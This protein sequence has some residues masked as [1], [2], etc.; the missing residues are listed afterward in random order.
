MLFQFS[1]P[2]FHPIKIGKNNI[3]SFASV[4]AGR[5]KRCRKAS[6]RPELE[7]FGAQPIPPPDSVPPSYPLT[8]AISG[9][10]CHFRRPT[11][12]RNWN[13]NENPKK[14]N[15][16][17]FSVFYS[18]CFFFSLSLTLLGVIPRLSN[19]RSP[20]LHSLKTEGTVGGGQGQR[21]S[22]GKIAGWRDSSARRPGPM[23]R[24]GL[25]LLGSQM[26]PRAAGM[27]LGALFC[28][29]CFCIHLMIEFFPLR[30][31]L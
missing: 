31:T 16:E 11:R 27:Q 2:N 10:D 8:M 18:L 24:R 4:L 21:F 25:S 14:V 5:S 15:H 1:F 30:N 28:G 6:L 19:F 22:G 29:I 20:I 3:L 17:P 7:Q 12:H 13:W 23:R 26:A 9:S